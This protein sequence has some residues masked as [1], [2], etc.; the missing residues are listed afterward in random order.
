MTA[1]ALSQYVQGEG[2]V[3]ADGLNTFEQTC[4]V[5]AELR[6]FIGTAGMQVFLRG[7]E[8][9]GDGGAGVFYWVVDGTGSDD[10]VNVIV[11][12]GADGLWLRLGV[13]VEAMQTLTDD[14]PSFD[15]TT[16]YSIIV[17]AKET[18]SA[19]T[20]N[21]PAAPIPGAPIMVQDG[22]GDAASNA[23][24][25]EGNGKLI[26]GASTDVINTAYG[27]RKYVYNAD[28]PVPGWLAS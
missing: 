6:E 14:L 17:V 22:K 15:L 8:A 24:T 20:L 9:A 3:D 25:V 19:T 23:I 12:N 13:V 28:L 10:G 7:L 11:P 2:S 21:L 1:P 4:D 18:G 5:V 27:A 16:A 26:N